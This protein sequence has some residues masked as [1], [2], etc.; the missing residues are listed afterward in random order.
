[1]ND[2][3]YYFDALWGKRDRTEVKIQ[4]NVPNSAIGDVNQ[5]ELRSIPLS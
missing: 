4:Q 2:D 5:W 3:I 1:M